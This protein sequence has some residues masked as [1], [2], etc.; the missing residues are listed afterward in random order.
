MP[1]LFWGPC[2]APTLLCF[3]S[4]SSLSFSLQ[5]GLPFIVFSACWNSECC[6]SL[7]Q[8]PFIC[9]VVLL[10]VLNASSLH[11]GLFKQCH[12]DITLGMCYFVVI[13]L[14]II[15]V[16]I[17]A[18]SGGQLHN[19]RQHGFFFSSSLNTGA[20]IYVGWISL[21]EQFMKAHTKKWGAY[22]HLPR[23]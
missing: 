19:N 12:L 10:F 4:V 18:Y 1:Q 15:H 20:V 3:V 13:Y 8:I 14:R 2:H 6:N 11:L 21:S 17:W 5:I 9:A 7:S 22:H 23:Q 16:H